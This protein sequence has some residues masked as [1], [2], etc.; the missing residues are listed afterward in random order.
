[1]MPGRL[2]RLTVSR[3]IR[4]LGMG[5]SGFPA[6]VQISSLGFR[7]DGLRSAM[8]WDLPFSCGCWG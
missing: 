8:L 2:V 1:M 4:G 6:D 3:F 5:G 7:V